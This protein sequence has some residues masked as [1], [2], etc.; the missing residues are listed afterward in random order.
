[1]TAPSI[2]IVIA[3]DGPAASGKGTIA[4][5]IAAHYKRRHGV[6]L[7]PSRVAVTTGSSAAFN[8]S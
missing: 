4:Q 6:A 3:V 7:D 1:M 2:A 8:H 5:A